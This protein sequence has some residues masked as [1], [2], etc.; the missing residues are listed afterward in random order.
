MAKPVKN[1]RLFDQPQCGP[2]QTEQLEVLPDAVSFNT[3]QLSR[4]EGG[5]RGTLQ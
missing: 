5:N 2:I 1:K 3:V 4:G